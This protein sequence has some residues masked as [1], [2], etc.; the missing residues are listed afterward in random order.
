MTVTSEVFLLLSRQKECGAA[1]ARLFRIV[2]LGHWSG[3]RGAFD[4]SKQHHL[5]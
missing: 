1:L 5:M 2:G 4:R 3:K